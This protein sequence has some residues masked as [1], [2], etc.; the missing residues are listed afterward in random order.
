MSS[1]SDSESNLQP[2]VFRE[3]SAACFC[4]GKNPHI[5]LSRALKAKD[6]TINVKHF[7]SGV[8]VKPWTSHLSVFSFLS[9]VH[10]WTCP[11][12][13]GLHDVAAVKG[14][15][16]VLECR[17]RGTP[18]LQVM[19]YR[20]DEQV[21]DSDD[22][23]ILRKSECLS[24]GCGFLTETRPHC[25]VTAV[26]CFGEGSLTMQNSLCRRFRFLAC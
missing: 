21:L 11:L 16:V 25:P 9:R 4:K 6:D 22:F 17:L 26:T 10:H 23:R 1:C 14:Q 13:Q 24:E 5:F 12:R 8:R 19:W 18:P 7:P 15:L 20:E 2:A 3:W